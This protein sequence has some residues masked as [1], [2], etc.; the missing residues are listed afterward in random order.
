MEGV[1]MDTLEWKAG[2]RVT[3]S[4]EISPS[5]KSLIPGVVRRAAGN[6][7]SIEILMRLGSQWVTEFR[8]VDGDSLAV[9]TK[10]LMPLDQLDRADQFDAE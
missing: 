4:H 7:I 8:I 9:R 6:R 1:A 10:I 2:D 5:Q 3:W